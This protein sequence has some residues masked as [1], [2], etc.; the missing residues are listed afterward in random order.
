[1]YLSG[2]IQEIKERNQRAGEI[3]DIEA[4]LSNV[5]RPAQQE[6][7]GKSLGQFC[8]ADG[9]HESEP[10]KYYIGRPANQTPKENGG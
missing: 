4:V 3:K 9:R 10:L 7:S 1:M 2:G 8:F 6:K 5:C